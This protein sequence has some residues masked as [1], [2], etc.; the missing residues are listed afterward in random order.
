MKY[1]S[2]SKFPFRHLT[3]TKL[4]GDMKNEQNRNDFLISE[5][6]DV[7]KLVLA[8]QTHSNKIKIVDKMDAGKIIDGCDGFV[9][10]ETDLNLGI[11]TA[12]CMP[13]L[14]T[15]KDAKVK[16]AIHAGWKGLAFGIIENTMDKFLQ[17]GVYPYELVVYI[18]PHIRKCCYEVSKEFEKIFSVEL[19]KNKFDLSQFARDRMGKCGVRHVYEYKLCSNCCKHNGEYL[20]F[21]YRR[22][23]CDERLLTVI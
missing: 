4:A 13:I 20:F 21:S 17:L 3:T 15:S 12:D 7:Q 23:G 6:F 16:A 19:N 5:N 22:D 14:M 18:A 10:K 2:S 11:F 1:I 8:N 9:T